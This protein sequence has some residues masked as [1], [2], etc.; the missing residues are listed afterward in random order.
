MAELW[1]DLLDHQAATRGTVRA[2]RDSIG[3]EW[4]WSDFKTASEAAADVLRDHGVRAGDR[5]VLLVENSAAALAFLYATSRLGGIVIPFNA[6]QTPAE[7]LRVLDHAEPAAVVMM[8]AVSD[9]AAAHAE[10]MGARAVS[11]AFGAV[12]VLAL[13]GTP[14][15]S[16]EDVAVILYT[17]GTT[18]AP[19]GVMLTHDNMKFGGQASANLRWMVPEDLIF[20]V[21]PISHVFGLASVVTASSYR[22]A[23]L[24]LE[25]RFDVG[26]L[27]DALKNGVTLLSAV[28]QMHA[29]LMHYVKQQGHATLGSEALRYVSS[30]GAPLDPA[31]KRAAEAF[32]GVPLQNG[33]GMTESTAG[34]SATQHTEPNDDIS[35]G[36][37]L[38]GVEIKVMGDAAEGELI[39]RGGHVMKG[40]FRAPDL[41]AEVLDSDGWLRT[42]DLGKVDDQG[43]VH[44]LG[45]SKELIIH[46]GFNV[47]PPEVEGVLSDHPQVIQAAVI[48]H[49]VDGDEKVMGFCEVAAGNE[50]DLAELKAWVAERLVGYKR[51]YKIILAEKL[52]A[53]ATGKILKH[54]LKDVFADQI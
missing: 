26:R 3:T 47:Y 41:T 7:L 6:R 4:S 53:A 13:K 28:P 12:H 1:H 10:R 35:C 42:G 9:N 18:G 25:S 50:P 40:Y 15:D 37:A 2:L 31:W 21:L 45:R 43:R 24:L 46:G 49:M 19:K 44:I 8:S 5:V 52:P 36:P 23:E 38:P 30:G 33:Y 16:A 27:H 39:T 20:G 54:K 11:G 17:T 22:G 48:G 32:Y 51:P 34:I 14:E 29:L